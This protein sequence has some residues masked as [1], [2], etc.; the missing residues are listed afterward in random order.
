MSGRAADDFEVQE[1]LSLREHLDK[2]VVGRMRDLEWACTCVSAYFTAVKM[3]YSR[4]ELNEMLG[5]AV[6]ALEKAGFK[7]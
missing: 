4:A 1:L 5:I 2:G 3:N 6:V 7:V